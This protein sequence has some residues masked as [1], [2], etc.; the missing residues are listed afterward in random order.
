[1]NTQPSVSESG[2]DTLLTLIMAVLTDDQEPIRV[3]CEH[4]ITPSALSYDHMQAEGSA[5]KIG[6]LKPAEQHCHLLTAMLSTV[7]SIWHDIFEK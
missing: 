2:T 3:F 1:M 7:P 5:N 6:N 4:V